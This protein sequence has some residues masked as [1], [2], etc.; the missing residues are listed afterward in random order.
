MRDSH[1][2]PP[3]SPS[4]LTLFT[5]VPQIPPGPGPTS[6]TSGAI[7]TMPSISSPSSSLPRASLRRSSCTPMLPAISNSSRSLAATSTVRAAS[8]RCP[9]RRWRLF[10]A[11]LWA[12]L[13]NGARRSS[14]SSYRGGRTTTRLPTKVGEKFFVEYFVSDLQYRYQPGQGQHED[15]V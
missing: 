5:A 8:Q 9:A 13:R 10:A 4:D 15:R 6:G 7:A 2:H 1:L 11:R 12:C 3:A 14:S